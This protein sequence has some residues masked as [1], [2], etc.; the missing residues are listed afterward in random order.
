MILETISP[1]KLPISTHW[2]MTTHLP[3]LRTEAKDG[4][5]VERNECAG[6]D[7]FNADAFFRESI[8]RFDGIIDRGAPADECD[9]GTFTQN[10]RNAERNRVIFR[11][12]HTFHIVKELTLHKDDGVVVADRGFDG[13]PFAS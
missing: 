1:V 13:V 4:F 7:H 2:L 9:V 6:V 8:R 10:V 5:P 12:N 11:R 3:V